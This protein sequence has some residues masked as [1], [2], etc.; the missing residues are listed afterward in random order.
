MDAE[1]WP[2][3]LE[4]QG[5]F[6]I[7]SDYFLQA[8]ILPVFFA[9]PTN[10]K[11]IDLQQRRSDYQRNS[12]LMQAWAERRGVVLIDLGLLDHYDP[13]V[14][15]SDRRHLSGIGGIRFS[16]E[17]GKALAAEPVVKQALDND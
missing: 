14:D 17:L 15:Y 11:M 5:F 16:K 3:L 6:D 12:E 13:M 2:Q 9:L 8:D 4:P 10:P 1:I 7:W